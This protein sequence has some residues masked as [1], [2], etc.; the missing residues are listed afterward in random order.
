[1]KMRFAN[2]A[3]PLAATLFA[4]PV[5]AA[6]LELESEDLPVCRR[7]QN[8]EWKKAVAQSFGITAISDPGGHWIGNTRV[9]K[10]VYGD[11]FQPIYV[12]YDLA[13][14]TLCGITAR[15]ESYDVWGETAWSV[16]LIPD[17]DFA[18]LLSIP[19]LGGAGE[20]HDCA[21]SSL[22]ENCDRGIDNCMEAEITPDKGF[23]DN[24]W[25]PEQGSSPR[26]GRKTCTY[27]PWVGDY[28]HSR[29]PEI[30]P[31]QIFWWRDAGGESD[32]LELFNVLLIQDGS[33]RFPH[34][35]SGGW[36][37]DPEP[38]GDREPW[39]KVP[40]KHRVRFAF[41]Y[42]PGLPSYDFDIYEHPHSRSLVVTADHPE[43][44]ADADDGEHHALEVDGVVVVAAKE[45]GSVDNFLGV[46]F[47]DVCK[48]FDGSRL[49]GWVQVRAA[50][51]GDG[52][53]GYLALAVAKH[54]T[55]ATPQPLSFPEGLASDAI[56]TSLIAGS[57]VFEEASWGTELQGSLGFELLPGGKA[58]TADLQV[59]GAHLVAAD[60][61]RHPLELR[62]TG[63]KRRIKGWISRVPV[64]SPATVEFTVASG[65][66][67]RTDLPGHTVSAS[68]AAA[69]AFVNPAHDRV[70]QTMTRMAGLG[71]ASQPSEVV[72]A[73]SVHLA[74]TVEW[75]PM[76]DGEPQPEADSAV[77]IALGRA[78]AGGGDVARLFG[79]ETPLATAWTYEA[80]NLTAGRFVALNESGSAEPGTIAVER[81]EAGSK[82]GAGIRFTF[83]GRAGRHLIEIIATATVTDAFGNRSTVE[84]R[85]WN[86]AFQA[87]RDQADAWLAKLAQMHEIS[88]RL[89]SESTLDVDVEQLAGSLEVRRVA[90][91]QARLRFLEATADGHIDLDELEDLLGAVDAYGELLL[92]RHRL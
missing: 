40:R 18:H 68:L 34:P 71:Q 7:S 33:N 77:T 80:R 42:G 50:L 37:Y 86:H 9:E 91:R 16:H 61:R 49:Q 41:E 87:G 46:T 58:A 92:I 8:N 1:M 31:D 47:E 5:Q 67:L 30:H 24:V 53:K 19:E 79:T 26:I 11:R 83:P 84:K 3:L 20:I 27:G 59:T 25:F 66:V 38:G 36:R 76:R 62:M 81:T 48:S 88:V 60:R 64:I 2:F 13:K 74:L 54:E 75:V 89:V 32:G 55:G 52:E 4:A 69:G 63:D 39:S 6:N 45:M 43:L 23:L 85:V 90:A 70:W 28:G 82:E 21:C 14:Q 44:V 29:R 57:L 65:Q 17:Q 35:S 12:P 73:E 10:H 72:G 22:I 15:Y 51:G 78:L 56:A